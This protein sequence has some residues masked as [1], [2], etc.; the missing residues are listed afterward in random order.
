[1][2]SELT[3]FETTIILFLRTS[4]KFA[5]YWQKSTC[6]CLGKNSSNGLTFHISVHLVEK[7]CF[8]GSIYNPSYSFHMLSISNILQH[9]SC[10]ISSMYFKILIIVVLDN[11]LC[12]FNKFYHYLDI[13]LKGRSQWL[14]NLIQQR[15][16]KMFS[17]F[18]INS[19]TL[20]MSDIHVQWNWLSHKNDFWF[21]IKKKWWKLEK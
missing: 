21:V 7:C 5:Y 2:W 19:V 10:F 18:N 3:W 12:F 17:L 11:N 20:Y 9:L 16:S 6:T 13:K 8:I 1:M 15:N 14:K 4:N